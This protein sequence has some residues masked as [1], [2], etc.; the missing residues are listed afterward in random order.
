MAGYIFALQSKNKKE[1]EIKNVLNKVIQSGVYSTNLN[2]NKEE[3]NT[4]QEGTIADF[5]S[6]KEGDNVYFFIDRKIYGVGKLVNI[7]GNCKFLNFPGAD[8]PKVEKYELLKSKMILDKNENLKNRFI[9]TFEPAPYFF[10]EG[11]DTD[12]VLSS[13]PSAFKMLRVFANLSFIKID[14]VENKALL[15]VILK[16]NE[17]ELQKPHNIITVS[18]SVH[19][20]I[21]E[22]YKDDYKITANNVLKLASNGETI[23][24]EMA[25]EAGIIDYIMNNQNGIFSNWDYIS[26]QV[27]ASP[28]KPIYYMDKMDIFGYRYIPGFNTISRYL[29]IEIKKDTA[30]TEVIHQAMK[31][32]DWINQEYSF[33]DYNMIEAFIVAK[34]FPKEVIKLK[35]SIGKRNFIQGR[36]PPITAE[37]SNLKLIKYKFNQDLSILEFEEVK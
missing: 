23:K 13:N 3:W 16:R 1:S 9:C 8:I 27:V 22:L 7:K 21:K 30:T 34:D 14:D 28:F 32:V 33:G 20:R 37:W 5:L 12:D 10:T 17:N 18:T 25:I 31:Y 29:M 15:D 4:P 2:I 36:R 11:I 19:E 35:D 26:H 6:M 24:H